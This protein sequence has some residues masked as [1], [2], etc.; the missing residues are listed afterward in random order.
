MYKSDVIPCDTYSN[1]VNVTIPLVYSGLWY[2]GGAAG[3]DAFLASKNAVTE[4][5]VQVR[6]FCNMSANQCAIRNVKLTGPWSGPFTN[7][8]SAAWLVE[9]GLNLSNAEQNKDKFGRPLLVSF[10]ACTNPNDSNDVFRVE[11]SQNPDG[12]TVLK[13][14]ENNKYARYDLLEGSDLNDPASF[15][16]NSNYANMSVSGTQKVAVVD[17][18]MVTGPRFYKVLITVP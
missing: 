18:G 13:W 9:N 14:K 17:G 15:S 11:I 5:G 10:L 1:W 16:T 8:V 6:Q 2:C 4:I 7:G 3:P 12:K